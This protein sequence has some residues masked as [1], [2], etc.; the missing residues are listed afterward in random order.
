M[1]DSVIEITKEAIRKPDKMAV[2]VRQHKANG[3]LQY[4]I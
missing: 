4:I 2:C 3:E 1:Y